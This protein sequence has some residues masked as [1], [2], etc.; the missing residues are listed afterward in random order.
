VLEALVLHASLSAMNF[1]QQKFF[2]LDMSFAVEPVS[3]SYKISSW[4]QVVIDAAM[5]VA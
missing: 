5:T 2:M 3:L 4:Q 1:A